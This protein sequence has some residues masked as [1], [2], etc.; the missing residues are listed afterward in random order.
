MTSEQQ[1][2]YITGRGDDARKGLG[3]YLKTIDPH[4]MGLSV[5]SIFLSLPFEQKI[6]TIHDL[7]NRFDGPSTSIIANSYYA[8][9][10]TYTFIDKLAI[11]GQV[12]LLPPL[13]GLTLAEEEM[14]YSRPPNQQSWSEALKQGRM[15]K[16]RFLE[17]CARELNGGACSPIMVMEFS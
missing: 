9:L 2:I 17:V 13:L 7:L 8:Y 5:D 6:S 16:P 15:T 12:L 1:I 10:L 4:R 3:A 11:A 14:F